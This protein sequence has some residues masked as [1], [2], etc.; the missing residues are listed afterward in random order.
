MPVIIA[1]IDLVARPE[2][3]AVATIEWAGAFVHD[4]L[5]ITPLS[6]SADK[7]AHVAL[8]CAV[9]LARL[10]AAGHPVDRSSAGPV[11][12]VYPAASLR[13]W[14]LY[15]PGY[16][17]AAKPDVLGCLVDD[18]RARAQWLDCGRMSR[19]SGA[20]MMPSMPSSPR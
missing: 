3:T 13:S 16:K 15:R 6:V 17:Q 1:G 10:D 11:V 12:E 19:S 4:K 18:L 20:R 7:I 14:G 5:R 9:L 8:R 2:R